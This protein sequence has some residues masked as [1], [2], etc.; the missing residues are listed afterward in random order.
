MPAPHT[1]FY[2]DPYVY[3]VLHTRNTAHDVTGLERI[4]RLYS[5]APRSHAWLEPACG[6]ARFLRVAAKRG[7]RV[8]GFD[9]KPGMIEYANARMASGG[10]ASKAT[11][12]VGDMVDFDR[13]L[14][15]GSVGFAFN[16]IN[17][18]RHLETD[19]AMLAHFAGIARVLAK[20]GIYVVGISLSAYGLEP[21]TE[22]HWVGRRGSCTVRQVIQFEPPAVTRAPRADCQRI[23]RAFSH[24]TITRGSREDHADSTYGLRTYNLAQWQTLIDQSALAVTLTCDERGRP[25]APVEPGYCLFVL[26]RKGPNA[27]RDQ[28]FAETKP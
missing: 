4:E 26:G 3:D 14:A 2:D 28:G 5:T 1:D 6:T 25:F 20:G 16:L 24:L 27:A 21:P 13:Q 15:P 11:L 22:D 17:T 23:E 19:R 18:I 12:F 7:R 10:V 9:L 8:V